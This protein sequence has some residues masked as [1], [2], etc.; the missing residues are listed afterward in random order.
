MIRALLEILKLVLAILPVVVLSNILNRN[1][2]EKTKRNNQFLMPV[3]AIIYCAI[4][5]FNLPKIL[6]WLKILIRWLQLMSK[7]FAAAKWWPEKPGNFVRNIVYFVNRWLDSLN[8]DLWIFFLGSLVILAVYFI[9]KKYCLLLIRK[10]YEQIDWYE[11]ESVRYWIFG[12]VRNWISEKFYKY[13]SEEDIWILQNKSYQTRGLLKALFK[14]TIGISTLLMIIT[15]RLFIHSEIHTIYTPVFTIILVSELFFFMD[16]YTY[17]EYSADILGEEEDAAHR[18]N[19]SLMRKALRF[20]FSDRL[21]AENTFSNYEVFY[22]VTTEEIINELE[23]KDDPKIVSFATYLNKVNEKKIP[24]NHSYIYSAVSLLEGKSILFN[25]PFFGD[26][27]PYAF[28]PMNRV[29]LQHKKVLVVLGRHATENSIYEWIRKGIESVTNIPF[30]WNVQVLGEEAKENVDIGIVTRSDIMNVEMQYANRDFFKKVEYFVIMEPSKIISTAQTGLNLLAKECH[31]NEKNKVTFCMCDKNCDGLVDAL[32]H[33]LMTNITE[34]SATEKSFGTASH[35]IWDADGEYLNNRII[36]NIS[37]YLGMGTEL[38]AVALKNQVSQTQWFG[39]ESFPVTDMNWIAKQYYYELMKY[40]GLPTNQEYLEEVF[41]TS[42]DMWTAIQKDK[43]NFVVEDESYNM[44]EVVRDFATRSTKQGFINVISPEY[45]LKGYMAKNASV[46]ET[47]PKAIPY[48][49]A[50]YARTHRNVTLRLLLMMTSMEVNENVIKKE[51]ELLGIEIFNVKLQLWYEIYLC[52]ASTK[53]IQKIIPLEYHEA[54]KQVSELKVRCNHNYEIDSN[55][56]ICKERFDFEKGEYVIIYKVDPLFEAKE[57]S[58]IKSAEFVTEDEKG[59]LHYLGA[60]LRGHVYQKYLPGQ[61][62]TFNG[63]YYEMQY[64]TSDG[65]VLIRRAADHI[66]KRHYYRQLRHYSLLG[67]RESKQIGSA[68]NISGLRIVKEYADIRVETSGY[69]LL[70]QYNNIA[71]AK[72]VLFEGERT[73]IPDR[74]YMNKEILKIELPDLGGKLSSS[75]KYTMTTILNELFLTLFAENHSYIV[76]VTDESEMEP[77]EMR[78]STYSVESV[79]ERYSKN[80]IYIIED[81]QLDLG[82]TISVERNIRRIFEIVQDYLDWHMDELSESLKKNDIPEEELEKK[83]IEPIEEEKNWWQRFLEFIRGLI[84]KDKE[85]GSDKKQTENDKTEEENEE[86][87]EEGKTEEE[88][89]KGEQTEEKQ[90]EE[91]QEDKA[92]K[93]KK[94]EDTEVGEEDGKKQ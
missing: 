38:A 72:T 27:I 23:K 31:N 76:A 12:I 16:G 26:L 37:R 75:V 51:L 8:W 41:K 68:K 77:E 65:R 84:S 4:V 6:K 62:F 1:N 53:E 90:E 43:N 42:P 60:E 2:L 83:R 17:P 93:E 89:T 36:P 54:V 21:E 86:E 30:L 34:V 87:N 15:C 35:M 10:V 49:S 73:G 44:F 22:G 71:E 57:I 24:L 61:F 39:G 66:D 85:K 14:G 63:K 78:V 55:V 56:I 52:F 46:F 47:D 67:F 7:K 9:Y 79:D 50:D 58:E 88:Q 13:S 5:M 59:K 45:I 11:E 19:Y 64:I 18:S 80:S 25:N 32:S 70:N 29:L 33:I 69:L 48:L 91:S 3:L 28:Y 92:E 81:S 82:L 94:Q 40:A 20:L 74:I